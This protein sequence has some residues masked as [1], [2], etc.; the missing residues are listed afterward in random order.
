[1]KIDRLV[2]IILPLL[3]Y[4]KTSAYGVNGGYEILDTY[5]LDRHLGNER[6][7]GP[8]GIIDKISHTCE[9]VLSI[10]RG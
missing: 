3:K 1:M 2:G 9:E 10:Y 8:Q 5:I 7:L 6:D 4:G